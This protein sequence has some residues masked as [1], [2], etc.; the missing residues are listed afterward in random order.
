MVVILPS[1]AKAVT[2]GRWRTRL[3][4]LRLE[5]PQRLPYVGHTD[6]THTVNHTPSTVLARAGGKSKSTRE[7]EGVRDAR[8][9]I[10]GSQ[11]V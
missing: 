4:A 11:I 8:T 1:R 3:V 6:G 9:A 7:S 10:A 5:G 2:Y